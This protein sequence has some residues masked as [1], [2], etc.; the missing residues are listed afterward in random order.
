VIICLLKIS[1]LLQTAFAGGTPRE[2]TVFKRWTNTKQR[3]VSEV[4]D[5][6]SNP[7]MSTKEGQDLEPPTPPKKINNKNCVKLMPS[8]AQSL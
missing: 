8:L 5:G 4:P 7:T 1:K 3:K 6:N 2:G